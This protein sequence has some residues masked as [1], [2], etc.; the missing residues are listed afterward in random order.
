MSVM[1][2]VTAVLQI[3]AQVAKVFPKMWE[4]WQA[5]RRYKRNLKYIKLHD[6]LRRQ[7][8]ALLKKIKSSPEGDEKK[9]LVKEYLTLVATLDEF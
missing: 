9:K 1:A 7:K 5:R 4:A 3:L 8:A 6:K 2:I